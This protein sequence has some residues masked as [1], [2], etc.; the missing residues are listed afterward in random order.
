MAYFYHATT[1]DKMFHI[2]AEGKLKANTSGEVFLC[3][4]PI[5]ACKFLVCRGITR[6]SV[7]EILLNENDVV[8]SDDHS[9]SYFQC[10]AYIHNGD[11]ELTR[12]EKITD[13]I[14]GDDEEAEGE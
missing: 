8:V 4:S 11:I 9:E 6:I 13:Y 1:R 2:V 7:I 14:F 12:K 3:K 5:D 10:K